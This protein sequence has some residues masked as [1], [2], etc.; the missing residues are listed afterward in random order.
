[1]SMVHLPDVAVS[2]EQGKRTQTH[3]KAI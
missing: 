1:L 2:F 3:K